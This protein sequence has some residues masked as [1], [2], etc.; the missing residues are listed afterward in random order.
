LLRKEVS[1][2]LLLFGG[3]VFW[4]KQ[5]FLT[6]ISVEIALGVAIL[7]IVALRFSLQPIFELIGIQLSWPDKE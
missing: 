1:V 3:V 6:T 7:M 4:P 2:F 5:A